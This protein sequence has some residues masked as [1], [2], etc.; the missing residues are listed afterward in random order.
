MSRG[1]PRKAVENKVSSERMF[2]VIRRP[3]ITEKSTRGSE[4][5]Q[6]TFEVAL[7]ASKPEI[8]TAVESLFK[9]KVMAVNTL[10]QKGKAKRFRGRPGTRS[11]YKKA[12]VTLEE[13]H[14]IDVTTGV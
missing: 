14:S 8:K 10:R 12:M 3:I 13:G 1:R 4:H 5:N 9:V 6:V 11:D 7:D 2:E